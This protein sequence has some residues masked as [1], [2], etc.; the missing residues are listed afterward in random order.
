MSDLA[1]A[2]RLS[3]MDIARFEAG[4]PAMSFIGTE[5]IGRALEQAGVEFISQPPSVRVRER[6][7]RCRRRR[8]QEAGMTI[9][10][11]QVKAARTLLSW[12]QST[13][14]AMAVVHRSRIIILEAGEGRPLPQSLA[15]IRHTLEAAGVA[16]EDDGRVRLREGKP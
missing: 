14:A 11:A 7:V 3:E 13:L 6:R 12:T 16:F 1:H 15:A 9:T 8:A 5:L 4:Q 2:A 10:G